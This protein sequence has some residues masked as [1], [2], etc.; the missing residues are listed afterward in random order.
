MMM[1][2]SKLRYVCSKVQF[3]T[4][5]FNIQHNNPTLPE[6]EVLMTEYGELVNVRPLKNNKD[7]ERQF[8]EVFM[9]DG[10]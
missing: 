6:P 3:C 4:L 1:N 9:I 10:N 2:V 8:R 7:N 5:S